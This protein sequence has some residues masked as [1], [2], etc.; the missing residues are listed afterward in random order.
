MLIRY[1]KD[2]EKDFSKLSKK[3]Q[4]RVNHILSIFEKDP[5]NPVLKNHPLKGKEK[6]KR[7]IAAGGDLRLIFVEEGSYAEVIILRV[8]SHSEVY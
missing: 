5:T 7:A 1:H 2:F 4:D 3:K 6:G 8:G